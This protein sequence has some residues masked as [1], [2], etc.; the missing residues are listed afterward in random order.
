M[1]S[2]WPHVPEGKRLQNL[3][4]LAE[5]LERRIKPPKFNMNSFLTIASPKGFN[6]ESMGIKSAVNRFEEVY[7]YK[8]NE[9]GVYNHCGTV[10]CAVGHGPLAGIPMKKG[11]GWSE[12]SYRTMIDKDQPKAVAAWQF[13]FSSDWADYDNT[14]HGGAARIRFLIATGTFPIVDNGG[15]YAAISKE[16]MKL[17][18]PYLV[19]KHKK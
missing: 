14:P 1:I 12:Y 16:S 11:E 2:F 15:Y 4:L 19:K 13:L 3:I 6:I 7:G 9:S 10:A 18:K 5:L 8:T 17:Y